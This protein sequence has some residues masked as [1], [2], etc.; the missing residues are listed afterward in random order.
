M[1]KAQMVSQLETI[2]T[3]LY[4]NEPADG[5]DMP[6]ACHYWQSLPYDE[7]VAEYS[8]AIEKLIAASTG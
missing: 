3:N 2:Y 4:R 1:N 6:G 8:E 7:L 5:Y